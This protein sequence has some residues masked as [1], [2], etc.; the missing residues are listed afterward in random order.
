MKLQE[1]YE[2]LPVGYQS[3][4]EKGNLIAINGIWLNMLGY[5]EK[6]EVIIC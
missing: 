6:D 1:F 3:L 4:D 5:S 2:E